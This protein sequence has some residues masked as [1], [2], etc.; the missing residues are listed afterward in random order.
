MLFV[1][2]L[3]P[4][5]REP[6]RGIFNRHTV[7]ALAEQVEVRVLAAV[8]WFP[9]SKSMTGIPE[10]LD[11]DGVQVRY[12]RAFYTPLVL[13][14]L[15]GKFFRS[16]I[17]RTVLD[18]RGEFPFDVLYGSWV[19]PDG[20]GVTLLARELGVPCVLHALGS[21]I[22]RYLDHP[23]RRRKVLEAL[24][25][26]DHVVCVSRYLRDRVVEAGLEADRI[27]VVYDGVDTELFGPRDRREARAR[28]GLPQDSR[29]ILFVGSLRPIK[30][31]EHMVE[32]FR[33]LKCSTGENLHLAIVGD[34]PL[35]ESLREEVRELGL[36]DSVTFAGT[37]LHG[38]VPEWMSAADVLCLSSLDEGMP[39]VVLEA[40]ASGRPVV[41]TNVG[42]VGEVINSESVGL[43]VQPGDPEA[44]A[45]G[46]REA[47]RRKW[48]T[49]K[50][51]ARAGEFT[52]QEHGRRIGEV[53]RAVTADH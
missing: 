12:V 49:G 10:R 41:A 13:R 27:T 34:G 17:R 35:G 51:V 11:D 46:L 38:E 23:R 4:N 15:H 47:L 3:Y 43:L 19:Y 48:D 25:R 24:S 39:N 9:G 16:S 30:G 36:A 32:A 7:R 2:N 37:R 22:H 28:L 26:A 5:P 14:N 29:I 8:P 40:L 45:A 53:L 50:L 33:K 52:W 31:P 18:I 42:G 1:S 20:Y 44:L 21:D 6:A